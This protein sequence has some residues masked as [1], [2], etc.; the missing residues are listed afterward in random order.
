MR[1]SPL[2]L[3]TGKVIRRT[4][5]QPYCYELP[6]IAG[7]SGQLLTSS[8]TQGTQLWSVTAISNGQM[9][10]SDTDAQGNGGH[11]CTGAPRILGEWWQKSV[12]I[13]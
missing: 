5:K 12:L 9:G 4:L 11:K 7:P 2:E 1:E 13:M 3:R 6:G 10:A 8:C